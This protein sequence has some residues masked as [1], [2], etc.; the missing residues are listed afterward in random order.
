MGGKIPAALFGRTSKT[1]SY[2]RRGCRWLRSPLANSSAPDPGGTDILFLVLGFFLFTMIGG[3]IGM[4]ASCRQVPRLGFPYP[5]DRPCRGFFV[6]LCS[7]PPASGP[8]ESLDVSL[9]VSVNLLPAP[10][11]WNESTD[12]DASSRPPPDVEQQAM[13]IDTSSDPHRAL[14]RTP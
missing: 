10:G 1:S 11:A 14:E 5:A 12:V 3:G 7:T 9:W 13:R 4:V 2:W 6:G 8:P